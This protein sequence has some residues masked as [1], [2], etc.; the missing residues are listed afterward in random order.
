MKFCSMADLTSEDAA[1]LFLCYEV[2]SGEE[3]WFLMKYI[4]YQIA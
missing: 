2:W 1:G 4:D 3:P